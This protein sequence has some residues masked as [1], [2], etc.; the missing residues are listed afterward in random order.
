MAIEPLYDDAWH[1][2]EGRASVQLAGLWGMIDKTDC[3]IVPPRY[4]SIG[5][6]HNGLASVT[7]VGTQGKDGYVDRQGA[8]VWEPSR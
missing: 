4:A 8:W 2:Y 3:F 6:L 7:T 1:F 5:P